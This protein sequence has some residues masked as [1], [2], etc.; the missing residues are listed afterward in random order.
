[1]SGLL[2]DFSLNHGVSEVRR[3]LWKS[4]CPTPLL[5]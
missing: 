2:V 3:H 5:R 4:S 1:L